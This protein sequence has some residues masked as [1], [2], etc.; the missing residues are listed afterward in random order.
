M[1]LL[2]ERLYTHNDLEFIDLSNYFKEI[3][4][5]LYAAYGITRN[6]VE[7]EITIPPTQVDIDSAITLGLIVNEL[8][9]NSLKYAFANGRKGHLKIVLQKQNSHYT[10][11]VSDDGPG[12]PL[13]FDQKQSFGLKLVASLTKKINGD[14]HY[15]NINGTKSILSFVLAS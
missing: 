10:L 3:C 4:N 12:F 2:H 15:E 11:I 6:D 9:S 7:L 1:S 5:S 13:T 14:I 8:V